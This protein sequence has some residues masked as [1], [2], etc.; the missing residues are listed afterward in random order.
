MQSTLSRQSFTPCTREI[1]RYVELTDFESVATIYQEC[2]QF[3]FTLNMLEQR[4][5]SADKV[6]VY[7]LNNEIVGYLLLG[8][9]RGI[10]YLSQVATRS[11]A[12][13][14]GVA[15]GLIRYAEQY[16]RMNNE[17]KWWLQTEY[18]NPAQKLY[19]DLGFRVSGFQRDT[20]G[21]GSHGIEM[22]HDLNAILI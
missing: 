6:W 7:L 22:I 2:F 17:Y 8:A 3:P 13:R 12:R 15:S 4:L 19:F 1:A 9:D 5:K 14:Q 20:Y 16:L 18:N 21:V 11:T 10:P